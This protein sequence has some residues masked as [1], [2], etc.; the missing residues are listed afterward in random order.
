VLGFN[1]DITYFHRVV[2]IYCMCSYS[3][4][5]TLNIIFNVVMILQYFDFVSCIRKAPLTYN[6]SEEYISIL[7]FGGTSSRLPIF[8][9]HHLFI[10]IICIQ[11]R[12]IKLKSTVLN[13][14]FD[15]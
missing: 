4:Y 9:I 12:F 1:F 14:Y 15:S 7:K 11:L 5:K 3:M 13:Y 2:D 10:Y 8:I 6:Y